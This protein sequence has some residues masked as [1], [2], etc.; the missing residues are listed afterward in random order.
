[1]PRLGAIALSAVSIILGVSNSGFSASKAKEFTLTQ[2]WTLCKAQVTPKFGRQ[3]IWR[4]TR[5]AAPT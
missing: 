3:I 2:I 5:P 1:M 4:D